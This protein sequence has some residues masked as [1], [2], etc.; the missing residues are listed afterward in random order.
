MLK[1]FTCIIEAEQTSLSSDQTTNSSSKDHH[2]E[3][4]D[5]ITDTT[6]REDD[7]TDDVF[8]PEETHIPYGSPGNPI[9]D[10]GVI[11]IDLVSTEVQT[12]YDT[13]ESPGRLYSEEVDNYEDFDPTGGGMAAHIGGSVSSE[14]GPEAEGELPIVMEE[15]KAA[16]NIAKSLE[17][18]APATTMSLSHEPRDKVVVNKEGAKVTTSPPPP[19]QIQIL[20][21]SLTK[22]R[23]D[24]YD[25]S[26]ALQS[27]GKMRSV[28]APSSL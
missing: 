17:M 8:F 12:E 18:L 22:K 3:L 27:T 25:A 2:C 11:E 15:N 24:T 19:N 9:D 20:A 6:L 14:Y 28:S 7:T 16:I 13:V 4:D 1:F 23:L 21:A 5:N 26:H 10:C